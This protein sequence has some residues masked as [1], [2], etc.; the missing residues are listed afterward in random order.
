VS[1]ELAEIGDFHLEL[2]TNTL[3]SYGQLSNKFVD[4]GNFAG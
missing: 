2:Q 4:L 3:E 1:I